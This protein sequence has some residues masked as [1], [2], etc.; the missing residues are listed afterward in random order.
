VINQ[1]GVMDFIDTLSPSER[2]NLVKLNTISTLGMDRYIEKE[3][4]L[5]L[6]ECIRELNDCNKVKYK[7]NSICNIGWN[8]EV[9][10]TY[11]KFNVMCDKLPYK[12]I[13]ID[14]QNGNIITK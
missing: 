5:F 2:I 6:N 1:V 13:C 7:N 3:T 4:N 9:F 10:D 14:T 12:C 8:T 11:V